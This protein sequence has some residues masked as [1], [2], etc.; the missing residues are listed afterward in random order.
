MSRK[1]AISL[2]D[3]AVHLSRFD[4]S[5]NSPDGDEDN[6]TSR[7]AIASAGDFLSVVPPHPQGIKPS[8]QVYLAKKIIMTA[9]GFFSVLPDELIAQILDSLDIPLLLQV[10]LTCKALWAFSRLDESLWRT[11]FIKYAFS[12][13]LSVFLMEHME[14]HL[15]NLNIVGLGFTYQVLHSKCLQAL[16]CLLWFQFAPPM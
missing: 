7:M 5:T 3:E 16:S 10:G 2:M 15:K 1:L 11:R 9:A 13:L 6:H 12:I 4:E 8:G 14:I